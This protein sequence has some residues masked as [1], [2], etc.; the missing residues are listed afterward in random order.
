MNTLYSDE[1]YRAHLLKRNNKQTI[2]LGFSDVPERWLHV[3]QSNIYRAKE[4][5]TRAFQ[6]NDIDVLFFDG[7]VAHRLVAGVIPTTFMRRCVYCFSEIQPTVQ[8]Q[9]ISEQLWYA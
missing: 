9:T 4:N 3:R 5:L 2:M 7:A 1:N 8:G 6:Q